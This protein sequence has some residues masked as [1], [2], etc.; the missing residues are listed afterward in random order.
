MNYKNVSEVQNPE[1][2]VTLAPLVSKYFESYVT[3]EQV[4]VVVVWSVK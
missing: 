3:F 4:G 1:V 2:G